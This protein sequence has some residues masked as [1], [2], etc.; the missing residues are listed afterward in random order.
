MR[1]LLITA[2]TLLIAGQ[3]N[4]QTGLCIWNGTGLTCPGS[5]SLI[6]PGIGRYDPANA[7]RRELDRS[8]ESAQ[9]QA[10]LTRQAIADR[11]RQEDESVALRMKTDALVA[12]KQCATAETLARSAVDQS[13]LNRVQTA[14]A[15]Q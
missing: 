7:I 10:E 13:A 9:A 4:A 1:S 2:A 8:L 12:A 6:D 14:C 11:Q 5:T 3:A 15:G